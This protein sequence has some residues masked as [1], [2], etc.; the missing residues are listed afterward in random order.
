MS[1]IEQNILRN[2][3]ARLES[4][5]IVAYNMNQTVFFSPFLSNDKLITIVPSFIVRFSFVPC[6]FRANVS[7]RHQ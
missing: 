1:S 6:E 7:Q 4:R 5:G 2:S 3:V